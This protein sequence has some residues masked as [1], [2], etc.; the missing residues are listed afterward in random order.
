V[1]IPTIISLIGASLSLAL[2]FY[3]LVRNFRFFADRPFAA[4][5]VALA[6]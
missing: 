5:M 3:A 4:G 1:N 6:V 2:A